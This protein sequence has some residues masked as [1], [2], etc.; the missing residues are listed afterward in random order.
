M[1][2]NYHTHTWRCSHAT[3]TEEEYIK[4]AIECGIKYMGFSDHAPF[5]FPDGY[6]SGYRIPMRDVKCYIDELRLLREKYKSQIDIKIGF[7]MEYYPLYFKSMLKNAVKVG[8]EY[9]ILGQH[10]INNEHPLG[11]YTYTDINDANLLREYV[12]EVIDGI[13]SGA[14]TYVAHP[15]LFRFTG[16]TYVYC[17]EMRRICAASKEYKI[18]LEINFLG[19]R[20]KRKYPNMV[21]WKIAGEEQSPVTFGFDAHDTK[22][23]FDGESLVNAK[24]IVKKFGLNYI[25]MPEIKDIRKMGIF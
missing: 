9:L 5:V 22:S 24:E 10:F 4:R 23:A 14:F 8:A 2:Y 25:G 13:K 20:D 11:N 19:I 18:P 16:D 12:N 15:D 21:F 17:E 7:E 3:G 1:I 6:E